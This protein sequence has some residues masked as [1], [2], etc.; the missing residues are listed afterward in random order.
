M[1]VLVVWLGGH[2]DPQR[3]LGGH[4]L[5]AGNCKLNEFVAE[6]SSPRVGVGNRSV[7]IIRAATFARRAREGLVRACPIRTDLTKTAHVEG[8]TT[9]LGTATNRH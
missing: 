2:D 1:A 5:E 7:R 6:H 4:G 8:R 3:F 9:I